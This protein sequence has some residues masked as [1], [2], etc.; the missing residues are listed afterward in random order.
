MR[1]DAP[2]AGF[3]SGAEEYNGGRG[4]KRLGPALALGPLIR[5]TFTSPPLKDVPKIKRA[6]RES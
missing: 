5:Q 6:S 4:V 1:W 2:P 3:N